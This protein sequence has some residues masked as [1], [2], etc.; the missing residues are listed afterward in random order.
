MFVL[1]KV[2]CPKALGSYKDMTWKNLENVSRNIKIDDD[3]IK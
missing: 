1:K 3:N 2:M